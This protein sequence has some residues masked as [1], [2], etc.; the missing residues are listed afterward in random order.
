M[1]PAWRPKRPRP[2][3]AGFQCGERV[4]AKHTDN[5]LDEEEGGIVSFYCNLPPSPSSSSGA[6]RNNAYAGDDGNA[7]QTKAKLTFSCRGRSVGAL[8]PTEDSVDETILDSA[9]A[10][11][12][13]DPFLFKGLLAGRQ[14][15]VSGVVW[16]E[17]AH[18]V[19]VLGTNQ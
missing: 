5:G 16:D 14:D 11:E 15:W 7:K 19:V 2:P 6:D 3:P 17:A 18:R 10:Y 9:D 13:V 8:L 12:T 1:T 4:A